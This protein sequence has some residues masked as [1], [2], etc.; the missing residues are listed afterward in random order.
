MHVSNSQRPSPLTMEAEVRK[1]ERKREDDDEY[2]KNLPAG[3]RF[4]P[5]D[6]ELI[7]KYLK[8]KLSPCHQT[9]SSKLNSLYNPSELRA[10]FFP[11]NNFCLLLKKR[12]NTMEKMNFTRPDRA[13]CDVGNY[14]YRKQYYWF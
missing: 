10:S 11:I 9:R 4:D 2:L 6:K 7:L 13:A 14:R 12:T 1:R 5:N 8:P 3:Y